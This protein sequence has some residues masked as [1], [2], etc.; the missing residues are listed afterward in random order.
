MCTA[1]ESRGPCDLWKA[2]APISA[3]GDAGSGTGAG[4]NRAFG[5]NLTS[6]SE[7]GAGVGVRRR[8]QPIE[9]PERGPSGPTTPIFPSPICDLNAV[10]R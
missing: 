3:V 2:A 9:K 5:K 1:D 7:L 4:C 6:S 8:R 10:F